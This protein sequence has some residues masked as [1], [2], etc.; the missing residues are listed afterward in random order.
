[1][2][3]NGS[4]A[5]NL[6]CGVR[7]GSQGGVPDGSGEDGRGREPEGISG[8][9]K[10]DVEPIA[11]KDPIGGLGA[12]AGPAGSGQK[13]PGGRGELSGGGSSQV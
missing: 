1:M 10:R 13:G 2:G 4:F 9:G 11:G 7:P 6:G 12:G 8:F 5:N 3:G